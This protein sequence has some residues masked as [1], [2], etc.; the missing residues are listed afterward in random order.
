MI[1]FSHSPASPSAS[2]RVRAAG[3]ATHHRLI[4]CSGADGLL[5]RVPLLAMMPSVFSEWLLSNAERA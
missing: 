2:L 4:R 5:R 3:E 1:M